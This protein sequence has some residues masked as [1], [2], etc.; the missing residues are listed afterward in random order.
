[1][2]SR[3]RS[4]QVRTMV[5]YWGRAAIAYVDSGNLGAGLKRPP[6]PS[7]LPRRTRCAQAGNFPGCAGSQSRTLPIGWTPCMRLSTF[8]LLFVASGLHAAPVQTPHVQAELVSAVRSIDPGK[9]L[10][11]ALR[12]QHEEHWH[13]Y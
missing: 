7:K 10:T 8:L 11:V 5:R 9:P 12:L 1:M 13:T 4:V 3:S 6:R 2:G